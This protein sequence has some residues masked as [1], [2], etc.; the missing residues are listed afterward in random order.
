LAG[1]DIALLQRI[2]FGG[3][4]GP[5][6]ERREGRFTQKQLSGLGRRDSIKTAM[7]SQREL[8]FDYTRKKDGAKLHYLSR[9]YEVKGPYLYATE[10]KHGHGQI[11]S[12]ILSRLVNAEARKRTFPPFWPIRPGS[13]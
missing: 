1:R 3:S 8:A 9:P 6:E 11:H 12:F 5:V 2:L 10:G 7:A 4:L 13:I